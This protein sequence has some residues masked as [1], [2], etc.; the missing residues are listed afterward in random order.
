MKED[1]K[2]SYGY[3]VMELQAR[4]LEFQKIEFVHEGWAANV[5]AHTLAR[6][7]VTRCLDRHVWFQAPPDGV[8]MHYDNI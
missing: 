3:I 4:S 6:G 2:G 7:S 1:G 5:D 8:C